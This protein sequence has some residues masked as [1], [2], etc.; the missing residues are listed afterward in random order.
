MSGVP[1]WDRQAIVTYIEETAGSSSDFLRV[2]GTTPMAAALDAD[3]NGV[4]DVGAPTLSTD[5]ARKTDVDGFAMSAA[6]I[7]T[8]MQLAGEAFIVFSSGLT[9][10]T[11]RSWVRRYD[12]GAALTV[13]ASGSPSATQIGVSSGGTGSLTIQDGSAAFFSG[14]PILK[15]CVLTFSLNFNTTNCQPPKVTS[16]G[17]TITVSYQSISPAATDPTGVSNIHIEVYLPPA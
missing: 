8:A 2:D 4:I 10:D 1:P 6:A 14:S 16:S 7:G 15:H 5:G 13:A 11:A 9:V 12:G 17:S 3:G